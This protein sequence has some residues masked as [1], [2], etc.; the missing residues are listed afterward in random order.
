MPIAST[1]TLIEPTAMLGMANV[2]WERINEQFNDQHF[3]RFNQ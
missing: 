1:G 2:Q 3:K